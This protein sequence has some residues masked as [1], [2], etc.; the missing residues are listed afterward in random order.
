MIT[1]I[2]G[3]PLGP[4][5]RPRP[6]NHRHREA[7]PPDDFVRHDSVPE[8]LASYSK[9]KFDKPSRFGQRAKEV[10]LISGIAAGGALLGAA[11]GLPGLVAST[12]LFSGGMALIAGEHNKASEVALLSTL[13]AGLGGGLSFVGMLGASQGL[14]GGALAIAATAGVGAVIGWDVAHSPGT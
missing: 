11:G 14:L 3:N 6:L 2:A 5:G 1:I 7:R 10:L 12:L 8:N 9:P 13:A 4:K